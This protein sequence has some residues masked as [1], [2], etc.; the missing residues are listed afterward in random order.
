MKDVRIVFTDGMSVV[1]S[2]EKAFSMCMDENT[3]RRIIDAVTDDAET[4]KEL[5]TIIDNE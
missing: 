2:P 1:V 4:Q 3:R 5:R